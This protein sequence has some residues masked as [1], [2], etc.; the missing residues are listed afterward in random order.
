MNEEQQKPITSSLSEFVTTA[1]SSNLLG[2]GG[3]PM[4][5]TYEETWTEL[6]PGET[7]RRTQSRSWTVYPPQE[8]I[9]SFDY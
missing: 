8:P 2:K 7:K 9:D 5:I 3:L 4:W 1:T 6:I